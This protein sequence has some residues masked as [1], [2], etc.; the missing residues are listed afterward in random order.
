MKTLLL[1]VGTLYLALFGQHYQALMPNHDIPA[2]YVFKDSD[3]FP[4][5]MPLDTTVS[6][7]AE[8]RRDVVGHKALKPIPRGSS[9]SLEYIS[10]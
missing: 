4:D 5:Y 3:F 8:N 1:I 2:G 10:K 6:N 7:I 9:F